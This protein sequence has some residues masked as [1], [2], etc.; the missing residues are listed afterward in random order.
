MNMDKEERNRILTS[1]QLLKACKDSPAPFVD[2]SSDEKSK[3]LCEFMFIHFCDAKR[4][5]NLFLR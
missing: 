3:L 4:M 2:P 5:D 1:S